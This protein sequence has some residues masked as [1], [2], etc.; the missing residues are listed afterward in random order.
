MKGNNGGIFQEEEVVV[1][2][3]RNLFVCGHE[4]V[5]RLSGKKPH[6]FICTQRYQRVERTSPPLHVPY[7][8]QHNFYSY[9]TGR[10]K[11]WWVVKMPA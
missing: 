10:R 1:V 4:W 9:S 5:K 6:A 2:H 3:A 8:L 7:S 11:A